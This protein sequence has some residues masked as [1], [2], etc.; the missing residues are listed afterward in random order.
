MGGLLVFGGG[1]RCG[2]EREEAK[3]EIRFTCLD[4][5]ANSTRQLGRSPSANG[6]PVFE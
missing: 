5:R 1:I 3:E 6:K 2:F 4:V